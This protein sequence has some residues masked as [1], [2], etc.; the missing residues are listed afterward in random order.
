MAG[1]LPRGFHRHSV[2]MPSGVGWIFEYA[3]TDRQHRHDPDN[4][5][6]LQDFFLKY[7]LQSLPGVAEVASVGGMVRQ[8]QI[9]VNPN[10][11]AAY[12]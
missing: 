12:N 6:A 9:E 7:E 11:L 8:Y 5:A 1:K 10:R 2:R 3:L 4:C